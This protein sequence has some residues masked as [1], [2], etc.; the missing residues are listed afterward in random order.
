MTQTD[1]MHRLLP[2]HPVYFSA[3]VEIEPPIAPRRCCIAAAFCCIIMTKKGKWL[4]RP[5]LPALRSGAKAPPAYAKRTG[6]RPDLW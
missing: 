3:A 4:Y 1:G 6:I 2:M 5:V